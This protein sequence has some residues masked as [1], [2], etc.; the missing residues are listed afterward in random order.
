MS[1][2][3]FYPQIFS[4]NLLTGTVSQVTP[5]KHTKGAKRNYRTGVDI[6]P[7]NSKI[8][9]EQ[10]NG[11][12]QVWTMRLTKNPTPVRLTTIGESEDPSWAPDSRHLVTPTTMPNMNFSRDLWIW[13]T[14]TNEHWQLTY[15]GDARLPAWSGRCSNFIAEK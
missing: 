5:Y 4:L 3:L 2:R 11:N 8:A 13:D 12:F 15:K 1:S 9:F 14:N 10:Q 7:D 6:A